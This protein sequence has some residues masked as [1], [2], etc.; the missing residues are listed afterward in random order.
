MYI[1]TF[2]CLEWPI[3]WH[4]RILTFPPGT[5]CICA[6]QATYE[7]DWLSHGKTVANQFVYFS[8]SSVSHGDHICSSREAP[9]TQMLRA[10]SLQAL[11]RTQTLNNFRLES[12]ALCTKRS[13]RYETNRTFQNAHKKQ[14]HLFIPTQVN[15]EAAKPKILNSANDSSTQPEQRWMHYPKKNIP[16]SSSPELTNP[17]T[18]HGKSHAYTNEHTNNANQKAKTLP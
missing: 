4:T 1:H 5:P 18:R 15:N 16:E 8:G 14:W 13:D 3:L 7:G 9:S 10:I 6:V 12:W 2:L 17:Q 11:S